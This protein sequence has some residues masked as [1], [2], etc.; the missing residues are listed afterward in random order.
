MGEALARN[1]S[2][3]ELNLDSNGIGAEGAARL[4]E[5]L[6]RNP[7]LRELDLEHNYVGA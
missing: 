7:C 4:G 1:S 3:R 5:A 6:A 2:L